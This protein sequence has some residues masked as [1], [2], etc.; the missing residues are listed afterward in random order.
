MV[1]I[2]HSHH[3]V[4]IVSVCWWWQMTELVTEYF[5]D[6][7]IVGFSQKYIP[8]EAARPIRP[9]N[10]IIFVLYWTLGGCTVISKIKWFKICGQRLPRVILPDKEWGE[11]VVDRGYYIYTSSN[12]SCS[13]GHSEVR[14]SDHKEKK[15]WKKNEVDMTL[16]FRIQNVCSAMNFWKSHNAVL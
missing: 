13:L 6:K 9:N 5:F 4:I 12:G 1:L 7:L 2:L 3:I 8:A 15:E 14:N 11:A 10:R 16:V